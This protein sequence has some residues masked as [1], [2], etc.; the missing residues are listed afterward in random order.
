MSPAPRRVLVV[1]TGLVGTS[2]A[3]AL[4]ALGDEVTLSDPDPRAMALAVAMGAGAPHA[5]GEVDVVVVAAPPDATAGAVLTALAAHPEAAITDVASI[6][7]PIARQ[8]RAALGRAGDGAGARYVGGHPMAGRERS[9]P[10]AARADLF[11]GRPWVLCPDVETSPQRVE[12]VAALVASVGAQVTVM[13]PAEH[14]RAVAVVSHLPQVAASLVAARLLHADPAVLALSG[15]GLRDTTRV[16]ASDP[17]LWTAVLAANAAPVRAALRCLRDDVET[18]I[19]ALGE[20]EDGSDQ[21]ARAPH[22]PTGAPRGQGPAPGPRARLTSLLASGR[23]GAARIP[24]KHGRPAR[25]WAVVTVLVADAPGELARLFADVGDAGVN[26][27]ELRLDHSPGRAL[28]LAE[29]SV[30]PTSAPVLLEALERSGWAVR[31]PG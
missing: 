27:E 6:K 15:Q 13:E 22:D 1:G 7:A 28:G 5:G 25:A 12:Q 3:L 29:V 14:D 26:L 31:G 4:R 2:L 23:A 11:L 30:D 17:A 8:V 21:H 10:G 19:T 24:G 18:M 16:A 9:G 20:L